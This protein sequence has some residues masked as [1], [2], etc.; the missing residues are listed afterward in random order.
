METAMHQGYCFGITTAR[1]SGL[2]PYVD[3]S[4]EPTA[5]YIILRTHWNHFM[6]SLII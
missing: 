1:K 4:L 5:L 3:Y 6:H 2:R